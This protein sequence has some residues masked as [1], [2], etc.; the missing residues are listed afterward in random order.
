MPPDTWQHFRILL[1]DRVS[2]EKTIQIG[3]ECEVALMA[4][5][6]V[7]RTEAPLDLASNSI[8]ITGASRADL[9]VR[10][11]SDSGI[12]IDGTQVAGIFVDGVSDGGPHPYNADG[13]STWSA[14]RPDY[15]RDLLNETPTNFQKISM[16]ARTINGSK[17]DHYNANFDLAAGHIQ[18][19]NIKG[20]QQHPFH[21]HIYHLQ[22][23]NNCGNYERGEYYDVVATNCDV[24]FDLSSDPDSGAYAYGGRTI[25]HCHILSHEDQGAMGW[26]DVI[27]GAPPPTFPVDSTIA[28]PFSTYY[29]LG[30]VD[31]PTIP[32]DPSGLEAAVASSSQIDLSWTDNSSDEDGFKIERSTDGINFAETGSGVGA[33]VTTFSDTGLAPSTIYYYRVL[34]YNV[35]GNSGYSNV[36]NETT[37]DPPVGGTTVEVGS[38]TLSTVIQGK[39]FKRGRAVV[40][41]IDDQGNLIEG[42][43]VY[44]EFVGDFVE[45]KSGVTDDGG[46]ITFDTTQ[47]LKGSFSFGFCVTSIT[48]PTLEDFVGPDVCQQ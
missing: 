28:V 32:N 38:I 22:M 30:P 43:T 34:A 6:G 12:T 16:G 40:V 4:R 13:F 7:W 20:A 46:N 17:F 39:G 44:G 24:R 2:K 26:A 8:T 33:N 47:S 25:M 1:A 15:L 23:V 10:C 21:L 3:S 19:W 37:D 11:G 41:V 48:H 45:P 36:A 14:R 29:A 31:P 42:A 27:G 5:D 35:A 18:Q 9:A